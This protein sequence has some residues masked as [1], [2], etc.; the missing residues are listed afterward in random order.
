[1]ETILRALFQNQLPY[2]YKNFIGKGA[3]KTKEAKISAIILIINII[4]KIIKVIC[5]PIYYILNGYLEIFIK[6][7]MAKMLYL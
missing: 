3:K 7:K 2:K 5:L 1:M 6:I 4:P